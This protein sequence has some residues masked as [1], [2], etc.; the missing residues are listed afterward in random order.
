MPE[1]HLDEDATTNDPNAATGHLARGGGSVPTRSGDPPPFDARDRTLFK[2]N[3]QPMWIYDVESLAFLDVNEAAVRRYGYARGEFLA[4]TIADILPPEDVHAV[5]DEVAGLRGAD[6]NESDRWRHRLKDGTVI[7]VEIASGAL[8]H[9]GRRARLVLATDVTARRRMEEAL[10]QAEAKYRGIFEN[11]VEGIF[12]TAPEGHYLDANPALARIYG[13]DSVA[14][15]IAGLT[16]IGRQLYVDPGR[17]AE[18]A[19]LMREHDAVTGLESQVRRRDGSVIWIS[20]SSR[21]VRDADGRLLYYEGIVEDITCRKR[22]EEEIR[23]LNAELERRLERLAALRC[24][25]V[26]ITDGRDLTLTLDVCLDQVIT[27]LRV[28][29]AAILLC[30]PETRSLHHVAG[31][32][33]G[34]GATRPGQ[35]PPGEGLAARAARERRM[36][37]ASRPAR[38]PGE[39]DH[40]PHVAGES[41]VTS[42]AVPLVAKDQVKGVLEV[43]HRTALDPAPE[44]FG[45]LE[46]LA[47]QAAIAIDN[48]W[49]FDDLR[50]SNAE[51]A[52]AYDATIEGWSR[53]LDLRDQETEGHSRRVTLMTLRLARAMGVPEARLVHIRRGA[54]LHD[55]GKMGIP[56]RILHKPGPLSEEEWRIMRRHPVYAR[57][58]L[59]PVEFLGPALEIPFCHHEHWDGTGYPRGLEGGEIPLEARIFAV[60]DVWDALRSDRPYRP[61]WSESRVCEHLRSLA[62]SHLDPA[63]VDVFL[64][65]LATNPPEAAGLPPSLEP[66]DVPGEDRAAVAPRDQGRPHRQRELPFEPASPGAGAGMTILIAEDHTPSAHELARMLETLGYTALF[67]ADDDTAWRL[68]ERSRVRLVI[69]DWTTTGIDGPR[70]C[71]R[72]RGLA[73]HPYTYLIVMTSRGAE[74]DRLECLH[75]GADDF[76]TRPTDVRELAARLEIARRILA[77]QEELE[78]KNARLAELVTI[79]PLTGLKNRRHFREALE[80]AFALATRGEQPLSVVMLDVDDFKRYNDTFGHP[81]GDEL[82]CA[83]GALLRTNGREQDVVARYGG[84]EFTILLP[85]TDITG[86][87]AFADRLRAMIAAHSWPLVPVTL[88]MGVATSTTETQDASALVEGADQALYHSKRLGR[89][90]V[91]HQEELAGRRAGKRLSLNSSAHP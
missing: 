78:R 83:L 43:F 74:A 34:A 89:D 39:R 23:V 63:V 38:D 13:Y 12:Q 8:D 58:M 35:L 40:S 62:G 33:L 4:M 71:R 26:A 69:T 32:G 19:R 2:A 24:I 56:D 18:F 60:V 53:A 81:A 3:P 47:G 73:D 10:R 45:F 1:R 70:L 75:A 48:A 67:A 6:Y 55:I 11:A 90:R 68:V 80:A 15:L 5:R 37:H 54:L 25:D 27:Q 82:L 85:A 29:A 22:A 50:R 76:L 64:R 28:D 65:T 72:I 9:D 41:C 16:D 52:A 20:E 86:S 14:E 57:E 88:S 79:D 46:T 21:A 31:R 61:A 77:M 49:L 91:T 66:P 44:W 51:L 87:L 36:L 30:D 59:Q 7:A 17:R 84:E 42:F